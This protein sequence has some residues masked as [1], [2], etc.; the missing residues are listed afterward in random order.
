MRSRFEALFPAALFTAL[1]LPSVLV[2]AVYLGT[3]TLWPADPPPSVRGSVVEWGDRSFTNRRG[4]EMWLE[5]NGGNYRR[6]ARNHPHAAAR[7]SRSPRVRRA[8]LRSA[9]ARR[10]PAPAGPG[11]RQTHFVIFGIAAGAVALLII[12]LLRRLPR[13]SL[14]TLALGGSGGDPWR[15]VPVTLPNLP[16]VRAP[17]VR[18]FVPRAPVR[19]PA[20]NPRTLHVPVRELLATSMPAA[21]RVVSADGRPESFDL[22]FGVVAIVIGLIVGILVPIFLAS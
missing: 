5:A 22:A 8:V 2:A 1:L 14:P 10:P 11:E 16:R 15:L 6:W 20:D 3:G 13:P 17:N 19:Q 21:R 7:L 9:A 12:S 4:F 18:R